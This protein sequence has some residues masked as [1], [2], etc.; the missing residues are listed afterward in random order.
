MGKSGEKACR[1]FDPA[2]L[3]PRAPRVTAERAAVSLGRRRRRG[4]QPIIVDTEGPFGLSISPISSAPSLVSIISFP[5]SS[6]R[7]SPT[8]PTYSFPR[9]QPRLQTLRARSSRSTSFPSFLRR[10]FATWRPEMHRFLEQCA[11]PLAIERA[12]AK[13]DRIDVGSVLP[14]ALFHEATVQPIA[15]PPPKK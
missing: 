6:P 5:P 9:P 1:V 10:A 13:C 7:F 4:L 8:S 14:E 2:T 12:F 11:P 3:A 15:H